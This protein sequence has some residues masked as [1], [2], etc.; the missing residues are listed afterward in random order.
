MDRV[1][2]PLGCIFDIMGIRGSFCGNLLLEHSYHE[3]A[4]GEIWNKT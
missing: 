1:L 4:P 2:T 3:N